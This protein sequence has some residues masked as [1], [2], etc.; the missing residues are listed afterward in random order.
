MTLN[1]AMAVI[2]RYFAKFGRFGAN[3]VKVIEVR[4]MSVSKCSTKNS[5]WQCIIY[6]N[7]QWDYRERVG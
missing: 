4:P 3:Y 5:F 1:R 2:L 7:I 6:G